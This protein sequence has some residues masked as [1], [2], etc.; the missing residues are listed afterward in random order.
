MT[1]VSLTKSIDSLPFAED[2]VEARYLAAE[3][4]GILGVFANQEPTEAQVAIVAEQLGVEET[5]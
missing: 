5:T 4:F 2:R 1:I 3:R